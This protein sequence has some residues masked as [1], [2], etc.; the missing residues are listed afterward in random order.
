MREKQFIV[1]VDNY[2]L[3]KFRG[4]RTLDMILFRP[5]ILEILQEIE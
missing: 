2:K 1:F 4:G 3:Q 5:L